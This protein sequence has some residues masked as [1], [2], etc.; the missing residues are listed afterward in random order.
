MYYG[1]I[2]KIYVF[3]LK[4]FHS[5]VDRRQEVKNLMVLFLSYTN[6]QLLKLTN[7]LI[8]QN[9]GNYECTVYYVPIHS[10]VPITCKPLNMKTAQQRSSPQQI[11]D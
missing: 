5:M 2:G 1:F 3:L 10:C 8:S 4:V 6:H 11:H 7:Y 9:I